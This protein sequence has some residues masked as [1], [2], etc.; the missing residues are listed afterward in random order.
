M[1]YVGLKN[2]AGYIV[3]L[4]ITM[5]LSACATMSPSVDPKLQ[6]RRVDIHYQL[7]IDALNRRNLPK[8]FEELLLARSLAPDRSDVLDA[9]AYAW[10]LRGNLGK[11]NGYYQQSLKHH[12]SSATYNNYGG[13][14]LQMNK[15]KIAEKY[16]RIALN[17]PRYRHP[18]IAYIN[19]GDALLLQKR[20]NEAIAA[21][22]QARRLN[23]TQEISRIREA[24]AYLRYGRII[25]AKA[26][27]KTI[28]HD[29]PGN[30]Q[31][32]EGLLG[33]LRKEGNI[34]EVRKQLERFHQMVSDPMDKAWAEEKIKR[35]A[36]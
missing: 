5:V 33:L 4:F 32:L 8:A 26:L 3:L 10:Q 14:M 27:Y 28:L 34:P 16:F 19:L 22:R 29:K 35:L 30:R 17:D 11:A 36:E 12:P 24:R 15:P 20:F 1:I 18:D 21:Y 25:F 6:T 2:P 7:G 9:L 31:A 23:P 13:L